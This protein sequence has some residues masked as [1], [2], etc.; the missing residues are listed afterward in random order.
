[1]IPTRPRRNRKSAAI[2][3]LCKENVLLSSDLI[4]PYF[5]LPGEGK[6]EAIASF[7]G[8][9]RLSIDN[10]VKSAS[11]LH[12][13]GMQALAIFPVVD[14]ADKDEKASAALDEKSALIKAISI[15]K[16]EVPNLL[17]I[18]DIA[19]DPFTVHGHD[20]VLDKTG[21]VDNDETL[22][23]LAKMAV[24]HAQHGADFVAPS[25][26]MD[27]R[28]ETLRSSLDLAGFYNTGIISYTAKYASCLYSPFRDAVG[29]GLKTGNKLTYQLSPA[30]SGEA[31]RE[32]LIDSAAGAD[33]L[34]VKPALYYLDIIAKIK[35]IS[36]LPIAAYHVSGEYA[37]IV[38]AHE[39]GLVDARR[40]F[41]EG[42]TSI[43]RAGASMIFS[44]A[45]EE[46]ILSSNG[47]L[48][49]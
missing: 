22:K 18:T 9:K 49:E 29:S 34:M 17:V 25:A 2:R 35:E 48:L 3:N 33:V 16:K 42:L 46:L 27:G 20:G 30:N 21:Y 14:R 45:T 8:I 12:Q 19:L 36:N 10:I 13:K 38:A 24:L 5:L 31:L 37:I 7:S 4:M 15:L 28:V 32:A 40:A 43:K 39:K 41:I 26:T 1:M 44:Y 23:I 11:I 6:E 47:A